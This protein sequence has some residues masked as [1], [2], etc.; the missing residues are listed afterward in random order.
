MGSL[1]DRHSDENGQFT[2]QDIHPAPFAIFPSKENGE[3][4]YSW[5][6]LDDKELPR[7]TVTAEAACQNLELPL[8]PRTAT[9]VVA[10]FDAQTGDRIPKISLEFLKV[11]NTDEG[12]GLYGL[13]GEAHVPSL[14][15]LTLTVGATGYGKTKPIFISPLQPGGVWKMRVKLRRTAND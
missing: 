1:A 10:A 6:T 7:I 5:D 2:I 14:T 13:S 3:Y 11:R 15:E 8:G 12:E 4:I 9:V